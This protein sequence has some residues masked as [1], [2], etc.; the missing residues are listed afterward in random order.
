[1]KKP[2]SKL[3]E[4]KNLI[5][6]IPIALIVI[7]L[8]LIVRFG[9]YETG[10]DKVVWTNE[11]AYSTDLYLY[12]K[13][14]LFT[15][16]SAVLLVLLIVD[17][18]NV[19]K[20]LMTEKIIWIAFGI[21]VIF[22]LVSAI[23]S[24]YPLFAWKG[25]VGQF[26]SAFVLIGYVLTGLYLFVYCQEKEIAKRVPYFFLASTLIM[27][28][29]GLFQ[30]LGKDLF[31]TEF[32]QSLCIPQYVLEESGGIH[33]RFEVN[34][35]YLTLYNPNYAGVY[36]ACMLVILFS[37]MLSEKKPVL[38]AVYI[39][40]MIGMGISLLGS[41]SKTGI[42]IAAVMMVLVLVLHLRYV[43]KYWY[44]ALLGIVVV[45]ACV[46]IGFKFN[47]VDL[48]QT[49]ITSI[50]PVKAEYRLTNFYTG[51]DGVYFCYD[52]LNFVVAMDASEMGIAVGAASEDGSAF[53]VTEVTD[54]SAHFILSHEKL[55]DIPI[56]FQTYKNIICMNISLDGE[57]WIVT[58][59]LGNTYLYLNNSG[60]W[61]TVSPVE[62]ALFTDYPTWLTGRGEIWSKS[63][64]LLKDS[65]II[66]SGPDSFVMVYPNDDYL[67]EHNS[68]IKTEYTTRPHNWY[69]QMA[70]QTGVLSMLCILAGF[71][72]YLL[73]GTSL[74][75]K[76]ALSENKT[77]GH[78]YIEAFFIGSVTF[79][80]MGIINDSSV[81]VTPLFWCM[82][83]M[84]LAYMKRP[85]TKETK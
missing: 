72:L 33:F 27:G 53:T 13:S 63:I 61:D 18:K 41:G 5:Y 59:Q 24:D 45:V 52:D 73:R 23:V 11:E 16:L 3:S 66:G 30:F 19:I 20:K 26:E 49:F 15:I 6:T 36:C 47:S 69:L 54:G 74:C 7:L 75:F 46:F 85:V 56:T 64:P 9:I 55:P 12:C 84:A 38:K 70:I 39:L 81:G 44:F 77:D 57:E 60:K 68:G 21:Y 43:L 82:F 79:M 1:M 32:V 58:N 34:R 14:V 4:K 37:L 40:S 10:L 78:A 65:L 17:Y 62:K 22:V 28:V 31:A 29:I 80:L 76:N 35:V 48:L 83:G 51:R 50:K 42:I 25:S 71:V 67:G 8:P 2:K